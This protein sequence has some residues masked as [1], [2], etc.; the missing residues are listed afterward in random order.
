V[1]KDVSRLG[2]R[3]PVAAHSP[4]GQ[5]ENGL[6]IAKALWFTKAHEG[7]DGQIAVAPLH[8]V[9]MAVL[10]VPT[11]VFGLYW[12]PIKAFADRAIAGFGVM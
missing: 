1:A 4:P 2:R 9:V 7:H 6:K 11:L 12:G 10:A 3:D 8:Y 5:T